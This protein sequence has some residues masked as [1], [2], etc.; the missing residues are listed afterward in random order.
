MQIPISEIIKNIPNYSSTKQLRRD[1]A[2]KYKL[3]KIPAN[4]EILQQ[5]NSKDREK[6]RSLFI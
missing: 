3:K 2:K 5:M 4:I 1:I 6:Y